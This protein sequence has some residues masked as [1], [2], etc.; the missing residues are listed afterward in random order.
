MNFHYENIYVSLTSIYDN[1]SILLKTLIS[2]KNQTILPNKIFI[3][4]SED[5]FLLDKGFKNKIIDNKNLK[6]F[7]DE[8]INI[9]QI[10]WCKNI[11]PYRKLLPLL[12]EKFEEK[13]III[14]IDDDTEYNI[15][16]IK[17]HL[18]LFDKHYCCVSFRGFTL[19]FNNIDDIDYESRMSK[20]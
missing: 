20:K 6:T 2:I 5:S 19:K 7:L 16:L 13:C 8:N 12:Q 9:F 11:G 15:N 14:T 18:E 3:Y 1:Q 10:K 17:K 4:L